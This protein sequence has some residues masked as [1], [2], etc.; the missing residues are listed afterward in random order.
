MAWGGPDN[1]VQ[2]AP[3]VSTHNTHGGFPAF[4]GL[5]PSSSP[6]RST[7]LTKG[8]ES[9]TTLRVGLSLAPW[10]DSLLPVQRKFPF[11]KTFF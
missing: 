2:S 1:P 11:R 10:K 3:A 9:L 7:L 6:I 5:A 4:P 8:A